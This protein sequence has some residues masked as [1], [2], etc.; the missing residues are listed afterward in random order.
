MYLQV[1]SHWGNF[2]FTDQNG[3]I[4]G[5]VVAGVSVLLFVIGVTIGIFFGIFVYPRCKKV[6]CMVPAHVQACFFACVPTN[7][8][9]FCTTALFPGTIEGG[10]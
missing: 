1:L 3:A 7:G 9:I 5:G 6:S 2:F 10:C 8:L 4:V